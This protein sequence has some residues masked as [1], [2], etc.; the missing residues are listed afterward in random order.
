MYKI[1]KKEIY[2][3]FIDEGYVQKKV[4]YNKKKKPI[5]GEFD[6]GSG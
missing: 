4:N 3:K 6:P 5:H 1:D 2:D